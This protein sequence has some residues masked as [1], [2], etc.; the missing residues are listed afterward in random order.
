M[1]SLFPEGFEE[2][3]RREGLEL[4][5]YTDGAGCERMRRTF[6]HAASVPVEHDW[7]DR[8]REFHRPVSAGPFWVGPPWKQP[9]AHELAVVIDPGRAFGTGA[10]PTT[11]LC[12]ELIAEAESGSLLDIGCGSGVLA[13]AAA[14]LGFAPAIAIDSDPAAIEA[15]RA[16]AER[17]AVSLDLRQL[18]A[19][20]EPL[21][22]TDVAVANLTLR[23]V[24]ALA[25]RLSAKRLIAS[26][27]L[28]SD[29]PALTA[30]KRRE[31]RAADGWAADVFERP[32]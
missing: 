20:A 25:P 18:D 29:N 22:A 4:A 14:K 27:Y 24:E 19:L 30:F 17:N 21:P 13:I 10:H 11:R 15:T 7:A 6:G 3:E 1:L 31:R 2:A 32:A 8:W 16:N 12:L 28:E 23:G 26:G 5:A 9:P